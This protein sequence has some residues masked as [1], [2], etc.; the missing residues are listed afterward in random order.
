MNTQSPYS[1]SR[2]RDTRVVLE[3]RRVLIHGLELRDPVVA[4]V[5]DESSQQSLAEEGSCGP[6]GPEPLLPAQLA[7]IKTEASRDNAN[8]VW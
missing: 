2:E 3:A 4:Q 6:E 8:Q 5:P 1:V 7:G